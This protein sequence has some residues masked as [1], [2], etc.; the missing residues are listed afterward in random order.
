MMFVVDT[1]DPYVQM[2]V[3]DNPCG[4]KKTETKTNNVNPV[5]NETLTFVL[6]PKQENIL[7]KF[8][9]TRVTWL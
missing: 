7:S 8:D 4:K 9:I 1:P 2:E 5:W 6:D 3:L